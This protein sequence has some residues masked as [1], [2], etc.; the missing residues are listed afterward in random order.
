M[1]LAEL[2]RIYGLAG[3]RNKAENVLVQLT[4]RSRIR[5]VSSYN[6]A[7]VYVGIDEKDRAVEYLEAAYEE[8]S[9]W[10]PYLRT[11][12]RFDPLRAAPRFQRL[13]RRMNFPESLS[14]AA[15]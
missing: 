10:M 1:Q 3:Q 12:P 13:L 2:G 11:E 6:F 15:H 8:R 4:N 14:T 7:L 5:P 9:S